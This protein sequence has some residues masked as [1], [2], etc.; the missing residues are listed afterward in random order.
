MLLMSSSNEKQLETA[1]KSRASQSRLE[2]DVGQI[3]RSNRSGTH[4]QHVTDRCRVVPDGRNR[5]T[6]A[7]PLGAG[8]VSAAE[9]ALKFDQRLVARGANGHKAEGFSRQISF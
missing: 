4:Q 6:W 9:L 8:R 5:R 1:I 2:T 7:F 3:R